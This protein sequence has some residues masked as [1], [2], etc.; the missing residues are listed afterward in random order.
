MPQ[1][2]LFV[3][4]SLAW[5]RHWAG[6]MA[7]DAAA[8]ADLQPELPASLFVHPHQPS[9]AP[10]AQANSIGLAPCPRSARI[11]SNNG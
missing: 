11:S 2:D 3:R 10:V 4:L 9:T 6:I 8:E 5:Q 7:A 1:P